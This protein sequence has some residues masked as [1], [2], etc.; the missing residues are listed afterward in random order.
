MDGVKVRPRCL[1]LLWQSRPSR[2]FQREQFLILSNILEFALRLS[3]ATPG[4]SA[5]DGARLA[6]VADWRP[7][8]CHCGFSA[9]YTCMACLGHSS[10]GGI[11]S[12]AGLVSSLL[13]LLAADLR[14]GGCTVGVGLR[15]VTGSRRAGLGG[16]QSELDAAKMD[17]Q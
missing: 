16:R 4:R 2:S 8:V 13:G 3:W 12:G 1:S 10:S 9:F 6:V 15:T 5:V 11:I 17:H 7:R 14:T